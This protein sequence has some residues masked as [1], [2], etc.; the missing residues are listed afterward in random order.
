MSNAICKKSGEVIWINV[1]YAGQY[2][3]LLRTR[4]GGIGIISAI[5][6]GILDSK[7]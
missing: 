1:V 7:K 2:L 5:M 4:H 3:W 6:G